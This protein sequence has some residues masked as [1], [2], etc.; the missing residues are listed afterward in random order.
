MKHMGG[1][2][3]KPKKECWSALKL[4]SLVLK[5]QKLETDSH[6][7]D[8]SLLNTSL[9]KS[10]A[11]QCAYFHPNYCSNFKNLSTQGLHFVPMLLWLEG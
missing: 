9:V 7:V 10:P 5:Q 8:Q 2:G 3:S 4:S 6:G 1:K 11:L